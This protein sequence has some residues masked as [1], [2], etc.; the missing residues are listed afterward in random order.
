MEP[1][2]RARDDFALNN[3]DLPCPL[4]LAIFANKSVPFLR[5][6]SRKEVNFVNAGAKWL[7]LAYANLE[8][9]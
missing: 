1:N 6:S 2:T 4:C 5:L 9:V 8:T 3:R 7:V